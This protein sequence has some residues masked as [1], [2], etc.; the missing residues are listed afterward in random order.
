MGTLLGL[1]TMPI[2][3]LL[4]YD[5]SPLT[6]EQR[7]GNGLAIVLSGI[8]GR[9][10]FSATLARGLAAEWEGAVEVFEWTSRRLFA[11]LSHLCNLKRNREQAAK[12]A[13]CIEAYHQQHPTAPVHLIGHSGG[14]A[15]AVFTLE[16]L[17]R[18]RLD[19]VV[20]QVLLLGAALSREYDLRLALRAARQVH[21]FQ[22]KL[23]IPHLVLG[24]CIFGT[25]D[26]QRGVS[27]GFNGFAVPNAAEEAAY[28][29]L[30]QHRYVWRM[31]RSWHWGG[32]MGWTN[33]VFAAEYLAPILTS[34]PLGETP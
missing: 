18:R 20:D 27:A 28:G 14:A 24:T 12:L 3:K 11:T 7:R 31:A 8:E 21:S 13:D 26:R 29:R 17:E 33:E 30:T 9:G 32:H 16:E 6:N 2:R 5:L 34:P 23:D 19:Q 25:V 4:R 22:S 1:P 15:I 10:P